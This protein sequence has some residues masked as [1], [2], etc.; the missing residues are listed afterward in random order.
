MNASRQ[1]VEVPERVE[2][3]LEAL[4]LRGCR[5]VLRDIERLARGEAF[6]EVAALDPEERRR[7]LE[8]LRSIMAVYEGACRMPCA[9]EPSVS[10]NLRFL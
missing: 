5:S 3:C 7:L 2:A 8:E 6:P 1:T 4:C 9:D 10:P